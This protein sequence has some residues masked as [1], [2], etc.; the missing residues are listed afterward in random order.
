[1]LPVKKAAGKP[2][3]EVHLHADDPQAMAA[4]IRERLASDVP[5]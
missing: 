3:T 2:V 5:A 4:C 1:V